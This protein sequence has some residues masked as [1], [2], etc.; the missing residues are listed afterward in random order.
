V[1]H[2]ALRGLPQELLEP[3]VDG[4]RRYAGSLAPGALESG[5][6]GGCAIGMMLRELVPEDDHRAR[7]HRKRPSVYHRAPELAKRYPRLLHLESFF[8]TTCERLARSGEMPAEEVPTLVGL[9][10]ASETEAEINLRHLEAH[11]P[12]EPAAAPGAAGPLFDDT[13][14]R[15]MELRPELSRSQ[16]EAAVRRLSRG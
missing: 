13:V 1:L 9:W 4:L 12:T 2:R 6:G 10:M 3:L 11:E 14:N 16:A 7:W 15:L 8:D 5:E